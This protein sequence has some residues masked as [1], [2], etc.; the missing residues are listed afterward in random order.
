MAAVILTVVTIAVILALNRG[1]NKIPTKLAAGIIALEIIGTVISLSGGS[2]S[3]VISKIKR[4]AAGSASEEH[5]VT[6][7]HG[8]KE[9]KLTIDVS[10]R[11]LTE[12]EAK[13]AVEEARSQLEEEYL[14]KN[15]SNSFV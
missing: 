2:G 11:K 9:E 10:G 8:K 3:P 1:K 15:K 5:E 4:P 7:K 14:A 13:K 12:K 6:V